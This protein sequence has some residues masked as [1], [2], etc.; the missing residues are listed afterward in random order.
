LH[1]RYDWYFSSCS[2]ARQSFYV[3]AKGGGTD[4]DALATRVAARET[5][6]LSDLRRELLGS[7]A[8]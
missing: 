8:P 2:P 3:F 5:R 1:D 4:L 6:V 7:R